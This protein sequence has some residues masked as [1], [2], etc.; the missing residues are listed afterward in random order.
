LSTS[1]Q[2]RSIQTLNVSGKYRNVFRTPKPLSI[3]N[4]YALLETVKW[5]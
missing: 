4:I 1:L 2:G 5:L 3:S